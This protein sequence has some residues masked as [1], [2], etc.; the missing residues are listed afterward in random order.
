[1]LIPLQSFKKGPNRNAERFLYTSKPDLLATV[2]RS[3][4]Y[5][6]HHLIP[7]EQGVK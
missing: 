7:P 3:E 1:M 5:P 2:P 4:L 6:L